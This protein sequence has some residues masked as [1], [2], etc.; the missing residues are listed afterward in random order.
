MRTLLALQIITAVGAGAV[1]FLALQAKRPEPTPAPVVIR[2]D[3]TPEAMEACKLA[4]VRYGFGHPA[5]YECRVEKAGTGLVV[6]L[7][8]PNPY[9][10]ESS[11][12]E[13][14]GEIPL[15]GEHASRDTDGD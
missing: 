6:A 2:L 4:F 5:L 12:P 15:G 1:V 8:G 3:L 10:P 9:K 11:P 14:L 7:Y 13:R